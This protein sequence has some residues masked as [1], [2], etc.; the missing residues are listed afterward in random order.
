LKSFDQCLVGTHEI[1]HALFVHNDDW[2]AADVPAAAR[3]F[4]FPPVAVLGGH[5]PGPLPAHHHLLAIMD[6]DLAASSLFTRGEQLVCRVCAAN[7]GTPSGDL[8]FDGLSLQGL[9][10]LSGETVGR[11]GPFQIG[12]FIFEKLGVIYRSHKKIHRQGN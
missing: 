8:E 3:S 6:P 5:H 7:G 1:Q 9:Q 11:L 12:E 4:R 2:R 10:S